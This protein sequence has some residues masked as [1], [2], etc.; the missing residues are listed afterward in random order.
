[1]VIRRPRPGIHALAAKWGSRRGE[2][3]VLITELIV[4]IGILAVVVI[5]LAIGFAREQR[6][7]RA[8]YFQAIAMEIIDGEMEI[9]AAGEWRAYP[10]GAY[11]YRVRAE[12]AQNLPAGR[13]VLTREPQLVRLEWLPDQTGKGGKMLREIMVK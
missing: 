7:C 11:P 1:M 10:V 3:G 2:R 5:P 13:F 6:I 8:C 12:S 4:A 9:L